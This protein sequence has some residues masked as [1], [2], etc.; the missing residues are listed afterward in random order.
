MRAVLE[1]LQAYRNASLSS[2]PYARLP[3]I[4][5]PGV[6]ADA[7]APFLLIDIERRQDLLETRDAITRLAAQLAEQVGGLVGAPVQR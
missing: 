6:L 4:R 5:E 1:K 3:Q 2:P 7:V